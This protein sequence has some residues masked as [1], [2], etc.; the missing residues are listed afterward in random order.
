LNVIHNIIKVNDLIKQQITVV[1]GC[2]A[3]DTCLMMT[4][5]YEV[6]KSFFLQGFRKPLL[7]LSIGSDLIHL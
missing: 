1:K 2:M 7:N 6:L 3:V 5:Y 4:R